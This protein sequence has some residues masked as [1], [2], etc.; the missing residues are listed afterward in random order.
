MSNSG[1]LDVAALVLEF[2]AGERRAEIEQGGAE[3]LDRRAVAL[4]E[5]RTRAFQVV[6]EGAS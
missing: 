4:D 1:L 3:A 6:G 5:Q 2:F